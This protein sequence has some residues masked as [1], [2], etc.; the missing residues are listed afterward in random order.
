MEDQ[1]V[2]DIKFK[3]VLARDLKDVIGKTLDGLVKDLASASKEALGVSGKLT[4]LGIIPQKDGRIGGI[5][6]AVDSARRDDVEKAMRDRLGNLSYQ[7]G[8]GSIAS[9]ESNAKMQA[10]SEPFIRLPNN[11]PAYAQ[12]MFDY[13][14]SVGGEVLWTEQFEDYIALRARVPHSHIQGN[15][16]STMQQLEERKRESYSI[17]NAQLDAKRT[18]AAAEAIRKKDSGFISETDLESQEEKRRK[19]GIIADDETAVEKSETKSFFDSTKLHLATIAITVKKI[20]SAVMKL[21]DKELQQSYT[22]QAMNMDINDLASLEKG[23]EAMTGRTGVATAAARGVF[24]A[25]GPTQV[26]SEAA[27]AVALASGTEALN[28]VINNMVLGGRVTTDALRAILEGAYENYKKGVNIYGEGTV[29]R[30]KARAD[31][32]AELRN[33]GMDEM[34]LAY[35]RYQ[36][37]AGKYGSGDFDSFL[38]YRRIYGAEKGAAAGQMKSA[39]DTYAAVKATNLVNNAVDF[40]A[41]DVEVINNP[42]ADVTERLLRGLGKYAANDRTGTISR[43]FNALSNQFIPD[44]LDDVS[45][46]LRT[47]LQNLEGVTSPQAVQERELLPVLLDLLKE[48]EKGMILGAISPESVAAGTKMAFTGGGINYIDY[49]SVNNNTPVAAQ[50]NGTFNIRITTDKSDVVFPGVPLNEDNYV[51]VWG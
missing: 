29:G 25:F 3:D 43:A 20:L 44:N 49:S 15:K 6:F 51:T 8:V 45:K 12:S 16:L 31:I 1:S 39:A 22:A 18:A 28:D 24:G 14:K 32:A 27:K 37:T 42:N 33:L 46:I 40:G 48:Y 21:L 34:F 47:R 5:R 7:S 23:V 13:L 2:I 50:G 11:D 38:R 36:D 19:L 30:D 17:I 26:S 9:V 10:F 35:A 41:S 4:N